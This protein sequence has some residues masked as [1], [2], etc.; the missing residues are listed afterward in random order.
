[1]KINKKIKS[2]KVVKINKNQGHQYP[3]VKFDNNRNRNKKRR[4]NNQH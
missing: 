3:I 4:N 1:M 2:Q